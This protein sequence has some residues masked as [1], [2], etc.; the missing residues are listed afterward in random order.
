MVTVDTSSLNIQLLQQVLTAADAR[1]ID[2]SKLA[3]EAGIKPETLSRAKKRGDIQLSTIARLSSIVGL[4]V[5]LQPSTKAGPSIKATA[6][7]GAALSKS[8]FGLSWSNP[9]AKEDVLLR[10][11]LLQGRFYAILESAAQDGIPFVRQQMKQLQDA[12]DLNEDRAAKLDRMVKSIERG[13]AQAAMEGA[14]HAST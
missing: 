8:R 2:Q 14:A 10:N 9:H 7:A 11:A 4:Q 13:F 6:T 3:T 12:G 5:V 1:G